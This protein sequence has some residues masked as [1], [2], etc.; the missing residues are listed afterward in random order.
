MTDS[1][2]R[3]RVM[4]L[5]QRHLDVFGP[6]QWKS[7]RVQ[8]PEISDATFW[9]YVDAVRKDAANEVRL[10]DP[11][12]C[13][14]QAPGDE[15]PYLGA[16][17]NF[18]NP[19]QKARLYESLLTDA[20]I[21]RTQAVDHRGKIVNWRMFEK[22]IHLR[23]RLLAQQVEVLKFFQDQETG[24]LLFAQI[25]KIFDDLPNDLTPKLME[26][27]REVQQQRL[28]APNKAP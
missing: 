12:T 27:L 1:E 8:C 5:I 23:D 19:L 28:A 16:L 18:Y 9:R 2:N 22:S 11:N 4:G 7:V 20:E 24:K 6:V 21:M 13:L 25:L 15:I 26:R 3:R 17:P 10:E 14:R